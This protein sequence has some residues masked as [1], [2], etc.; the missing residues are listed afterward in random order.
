M[1]TQCLC[2]NDPN[3]LLILSAAP[4]WIPWLPRIWDN[5]RTHYART[6]RSHSSRPVHQRVRGVTRA[7]GAQSK[8]MWGR[9]EWQKESDGRVVYKIQSQ[10]GWLTALTSCVRRSISSRSGHCSLRQY[11]DPWRA[12][13]LECNV[14]AEL[15]HIR[16]AAVGRIQW[17]GV[18]CSL[19]H[20]PLLMYT[21]W[22]FGRSMR[23]LVLECMYCMCEG[24]LDVR[25]VCT[26]EWKGRLRLAPVGTIGYKIKRD[27]QQLTPVF[28]FLLLF[29][30]IYRHAYLCG[31]SVC[32][33]MNAQVQ[34]CVHAHACTPLHACMPLW[35]PH[36]KV[37]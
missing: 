24:L 13:G 29:L 28:F 22:L 37:D 23:S 2:S 3:C 14:P 30:Q 17:W 10:W 25:C 15:Q 34:Q 16:K 33:N 9:E 36:Y 5:T 6:P 26:C 8:P 20:W 18:Q 21:F 4:H 11:T 35:S 7:S 32:L 27:S 12:L 31:L 1:I 19:Q